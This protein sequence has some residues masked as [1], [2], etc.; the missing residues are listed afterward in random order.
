ME[1]TTHP[2][3]GLVLEKFL[4]LEQEGKYAPLAR[5]SDNGINLLDMDGNIV[6]GVDLADDVD[7]NVE[8]EMLHEFQDRRARHFNRAREAWPAVR[9]QHK[10][11]P[12]EEMDRFYAFYR[13]MPRTED[14]DWEGLTM[15][16]EMLRAWQN[17]G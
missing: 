10:G 16:L 5:W 7:G 15:P 11:P 8:F 4:A 9:D 1:T 2:Q 6:G 13:D 3:Y 12:E 17:K 14:E